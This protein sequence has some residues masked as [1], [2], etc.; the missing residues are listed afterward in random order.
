VQLT[1]NY[2]SIEVEALMPLTVKSY[3]S[4]AKETVTFEFNNENNEKVGFQMFN[5]NGQE[6]ILKPDVDSNMITVKRGELETG[7]YMYSLQVGSQIA[8]G[9]IQ[10]VD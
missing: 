3:P 4:P 2:A 1:S 9:Q 10:F 7:V 5:M 8:K 6:V